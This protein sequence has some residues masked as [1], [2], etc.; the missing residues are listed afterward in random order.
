MK[1][2]RRKP[3]PDRPPPINKKFWLRVLLNDLFFYK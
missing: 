2:M 3:Q 1:N